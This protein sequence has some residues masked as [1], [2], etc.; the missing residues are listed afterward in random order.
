MCVQV[1]QYAPNVVQGMLSLLKNCPHEVAHL[2]RDLLVAARYI[3]G[4]ELRVRFI[5]CID[6]LFNEDIF[7]GTGWT[8]RDAVRSMAYSILV[9]VVHHVRGQLSLNHL[10]LAVQLFSKNVH[11]P[12][13]PVTIQ[14]ISCKLLLNLMESIRVKTEQE[15]TVSANPGLIVGK[16]TSQYQLVKKKPISLLWL[17]SV[18]MCLYNTIYW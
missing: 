2:R 13:L 1:N 8:T 12:T 3:L 17:G 5:P 18:V 11:D 14:N 7:I 16:G 6:Q 4:T 10:S 9:D 15:L